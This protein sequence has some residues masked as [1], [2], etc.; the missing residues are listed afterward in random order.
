MSSVLVVEDSIDSFHLIRR[1]LSSLHLRNVQTIREAK[2]ALMEST[3]DLILLDAHLP[4]GD[5]FGLCS[6]LRTDHAFTFTPVIFITAKDQIADKV[7]GFSVGADD[8]ITKPFEPVEL[9]AR[10]EAKLRKKRLSLV[11][12]DIMEFGDIL[13]DRSRQ[14]VFVNT[15]TDMHE[16]HLTATE[17]KLLVVLATSPNQVVSRDEILNS[18]WG[19]SVH[20]FSRC[21]DT[22]V[23]KLRRKLG[24]F[25]DCIQSGHGK[26]YSFS[27]SEHG[28]T[29][30]LVE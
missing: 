17:F 19:N 18:I 10:V 16:V 4:D 12:K 15:K 7:L 11:K 13:I 5:S 1:A 2:A 27:S 14:K 9:C 21:V 6:L 28:Q 30:V 20:V 24:K 26:G 23:S 22:H 25:R 29:R 3:F 8:Y